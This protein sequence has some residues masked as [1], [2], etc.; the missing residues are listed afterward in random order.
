MMDSKIQRNLE[1]SIL[2]EHAVILNP[3]AGGEYG[4]IPDQ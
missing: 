3:E 4:E 1:S 2:Q